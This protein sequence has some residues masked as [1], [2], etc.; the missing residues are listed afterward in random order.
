MTQEYQS[1]SNLLRRCSI[2]FLLGMSLAAFSPCLDFPFD[3][4]LDD[5]KWIQSGTLS[6]GVF[7]DE[8]WQRIEPDEDVAQSPMETELSKGKV[9]Q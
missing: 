7:F 2:P 1:E 6:N 4:Q 9:T 8:I 5:N 3:C